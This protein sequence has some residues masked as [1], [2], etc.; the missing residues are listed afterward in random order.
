VLLRERE[1]YLYQKGKWHTYSYFYCISDF[2]NVHDIF[3]F[4]SKV[5]LCLEFLVVCS[6]PQ[7][8]LARNGSALKN[9]AKACFIFGW[10]IVLELKTTTLMKHLGGLALLGLCWV[11]TQ[12]H[13]HGGFNR[14]CGGFHLR[15]HLWMATQEQR[16][17]YV[18][19]ALVCFQC[20]LRH[21]GLCLDH[22]RLWG[23][24]CLQD[25]GW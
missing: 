18:F 17:Y 21:Y 16:D 6:H 11:A 14:A 1:H 4:Q 15:V 5:L 12:D 19:H 23:S 3:C 22:I 7:T 20:S 25:I 10:E 24:T 2:N 9:Y 13:V 8:P